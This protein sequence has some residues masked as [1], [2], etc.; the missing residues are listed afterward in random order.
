MSCE[1]DLAKG[2]DSFGRALF[3]QESDQILVAVANDSSLLLDC[4]ASDSRGREIVKAEIGAIGKVGIEFSLPRA[5]RTGRDVDE[6]GLIHDVER[7]IEHG[8]I[9]MIAGVVRAAGAEL[10][11]ALGFSDKSRV[12][13]KRGEVDKVDERKHL[14]GFA[15]TSCVGENT[16]LE[17]TLELDRP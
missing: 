12:F 3:V 14:D 16:T 6:G 4:G 13:P 11:F 8:D 2:L 7:V 9:P 15:D 1:D 5:E 10:D 17:F